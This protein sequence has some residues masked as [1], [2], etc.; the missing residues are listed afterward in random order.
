MK[1]S[2]FPSSPLLLLMPIMAIALGSLITNG[3]V[4]NDGTESGNNAYYDIPIPVGQTSRGLLIPNFDQRGNKESV[5]SAGQAKRLSQENLELSNLEITLYD[6]RDAAGMN[7][8]IPK[9][10]YS[11]ETKILRSKTQA[12]IQRNDFKLWGEALEFDT[13]TKVGRLF[14]NVTM[15]IDDANLAIPD[16]AAEKYANKNK[17]D[18]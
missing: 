9:A 17:A 14:G 6:A 16:A 7:I 3:A 12:H 13:N 2:L 10:I 4:K 8:S 5:L 15:L 1:S 18:D 11:L